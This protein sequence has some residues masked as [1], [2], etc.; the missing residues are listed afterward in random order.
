MANVVIDTSAWIRFFRYGND[1][2]SQFVAELVM[3]DQA[4]VTGVVLTELLQGL[5]T[6]KE[7]QHLTALFSSLPFIETVRADWQNA[8]EDLQ[9]LRRRG[10]T[11][12]VTDAVIATVAHR[13]GLAVLTTDPHFQSFKVNRVGPLK[14]P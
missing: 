14:V 10:I 8:G 12:P 11:V 13:R 6:E 4:V 2:V 1:E 7:R 5:K 9:E 3:N